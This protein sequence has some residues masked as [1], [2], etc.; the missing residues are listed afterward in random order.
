MAAP[1]VSGA[2]A[3]LLQREPTLTQP[4]VKTLLQAG[5]R[6]PEGTVLVEQQVGPGALDLVGSLQVLEAMSA[7]VVVE[8]A[9][10][11]SWIALAASYAHPDPAWPLAGVLQLRNSA[12]EIA[13]VPAARLR[14]EAEPAIVTTPLTRVAPGMWEFA[15]AAPAGSGLGELT[16]RV[17]LDGKLLVERV[18]PIAT[19]PWVAEHGVEARG[20]C[21]LGRTRAPEALAAWVTLLIAAV[22][23]RP[24]PGTPRHRKKSSR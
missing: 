1:I 6:R 5:A 11:Q 12:E 16:L 19:D 20:G 13:D 15:V 23:R 21:S 17:F 3:L 7:P 10:G 18:T 8:P 2:V 4:E 14:L 24:S 22:R 9:A